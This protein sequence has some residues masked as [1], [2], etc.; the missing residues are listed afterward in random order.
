LAIIALLGT[1]EAQAQVIPIAAARALPP[2]SVVTI[3]GAVSVP[4]GRYSAS[5]F[6]QGFGLQDFTGG[7]YVSSAFNSGLTLWQLARV[8]G[9]VG[10]D[11]FG[12]LVVRPAAPADV[13]R[14]SA[15]FPVLP[16]PVATG[17]VGEATEGKLVRVTG[18][19]TRP[20]VN[21]LPFG[22]Q[23]FIDDGSGEVQVFIPASTGID[24]FTLPYVQPG[25]RI[26]AVGQSAQF[27]AQN[28][29][30]PRFWFDL[31]PAF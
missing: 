10:D 12:V 29:V 3:Q 23:V 1:V 6:D 31:L 20:V 14:L 21:D 7:V 13:V 16:T 15:W 2:G 4:S 24:P 17:A 11:G 22:Y 8:T 19:V 18:V 26:R 9:V 25:K 30:L 28:E 5:T 27:L